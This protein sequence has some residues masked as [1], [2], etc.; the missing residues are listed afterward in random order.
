[1][2]ELILPDLCPVGTEHEPFVETEQENTEFWGAPQTTIRLTITCANCGQ[3]Y[4]PRHEEPY[5]EACSN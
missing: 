5:E 4:R 3:A 1:M 2:N